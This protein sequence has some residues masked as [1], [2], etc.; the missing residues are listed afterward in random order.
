MSA[1]MLLIVKHKDRLY[2]EPW[3]GQAFSHFTL[4]LKRSML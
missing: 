4:G 2:K 3:A 1:A